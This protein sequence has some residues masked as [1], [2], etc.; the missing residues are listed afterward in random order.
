MDRLLNTL[1][2]VI[3]YLLSKSADHKP[4]IW[5]TFQT[6]KSLQRISPVYYR[7]MNNLLYGVEHNNCLSKD[8]EFHLNSWVKNHWQLC[9]Q[10][11]FV[12]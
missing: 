3:L 5:M 4:E 2:I 9:G 11:L 7:K 1:S 12:H 10:L 6:L 8:T